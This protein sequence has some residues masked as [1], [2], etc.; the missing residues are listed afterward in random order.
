MKRDAVIGYSRQQGQTRTVPRKPGRVIILLN[1]LAQVYITNQWQ[2]YILNSR[3]SDS[4]H[5]VSLHLYWSISYT[6]VP[7]RT[8]RELGLW[9]LC[10]ASHC[11]T[12]VCPER[13]IIISLS[14]GKSPW[15]F[16]KL[17]CLL[18]SFLIHGT[19]LSAV[20]RKAWTLESG[21]CVHKCEFWCL[22]FDL[23]NI[24]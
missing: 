24:T 15:L 2:S 14:N 22:T 4:S 18:A 12:A 10:F 3:L 11:L 5:T 20:G 17:V 16:T 21:R 13:V 19:L 7:S 23:G 6:L 1:Y 8:T 9:P